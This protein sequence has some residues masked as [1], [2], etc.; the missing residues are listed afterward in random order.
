MARQ[1]GVKSIKRHQK[2]QLRSKVD[3]ALKAILKQVSSTPKM[4]SSFEGHRVNAGEYADEFGRVWQIQLHVTCSKRKQIKDVG[5]VPMYAKWDVR[6]RI[7]AWAAY[8][9]D[10]LS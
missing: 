1:R 3:P 2:S 10:W 6:L 5:V 9:A 7:R 4:P 8:L